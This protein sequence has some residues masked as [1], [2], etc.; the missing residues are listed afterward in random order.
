VAQIRKIGGESIF[1]ARH[2]SI[3]MIRGVLAAMDY[4]FENLTP[5]KFQLFCQALL[6]R[7]YPSVQCLPVAQPD[8]GRDAVYWRDHK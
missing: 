5:E 2:K 4:P 8:G 6:V 1:I 7:E 3:I